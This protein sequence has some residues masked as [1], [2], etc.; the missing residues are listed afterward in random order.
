MGIVYRADDP[1]LNRT[2][3][4]KTIA[5]MEDPTACAEYESR[6]YQEAK[7][8]GGLNHPNLITINDIGR[9]GDIAYMAMELLEGIELRKLMAQGPCP[10]PFAL[11]ILAQVADGLA[12][13]H[14]RGVIHRD[15]KPANIMVVRDRFAKIMDFGI[16]RMRVSDVK[17]Q[18]GNILGSPKYMSP[19][20]MTGQPADRRSDIFSLGIVL[21][22]LTA[23]E[24]PFSAPNVSQLMQQIAVATPRPPSAVKPA[25]PAMLD[26]IVAK[27]LEK[28]PDARYQS[29]A[30]LAADL[31]AC[32]AELTGQPAAATPAVETVATI[33]LD[34]P[35]AE[36]MEIAKTLP[37]EGDSAATTPPA[38][39]ATIAEAW[40]HF[41]LSRRFDSNTALRRLEA[42]STA[43]GASELP[44]AARASSSHVPLLRLWRDPGKRA[45]AAAVIAATLVALGIA[46]I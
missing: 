38:M 35:A 36:N 1:L 4:I 20:Q 8:A 15:I 41:S 44:A 42:F 12:H 31:R 30:A 24:P 34:I 37:L 10:L 2:V 27:A 33:E 21:Y 23:G 40:T 6:F 17:T 22:E 16:A 18:T 32:M 28:R 39:S 5:M 13:A 9:E 29:A 46:F 11:D 3:A 25:L 14:E 43:Q 26:L 45:F 7:A 19:E